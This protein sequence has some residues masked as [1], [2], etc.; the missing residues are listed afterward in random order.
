MPY[1][2]GN[3]PI[4]PERRKQFEELRSLRDSMFDESRIIKDLYHEF[5]KVRKYQNSKQMWNYAISLTKSQLEKLVEDH[6]VIFVSIM[7][8][9]YVL[10]A[11]LQQ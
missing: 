3:E 5:V 8:Q 11:F 7:W 9:L 2:V 4:E 1:R 6:V 10:V